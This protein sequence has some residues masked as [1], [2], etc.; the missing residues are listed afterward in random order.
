MPPLFGDPLVPIQASPPDTTGD[1]NVDD[2][3]AAAQRT[4]LV[5]RIKRPSSCASTDHTVGAPRSRLTPFRVPSRPNIGQSSAP[6][7]PTPQSPPHTTAAT[8]IIREMSFNIRCDLSF[9]MRDKN[10]PAFS[11]RVIL[12]RV[13]I[14]RVWHPTRCGLNS[15]DAIDRA[16][17]STGDQEFD[18]S[19]LSGK[20]S[21]VAR[22]S[23]VRATE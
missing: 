15:Q 10:A 16:A 13:D 9:V 20:S 19:K 11:F 3:S 22:G 23:N 14:F 12:F 7:E 6:V 17:E 8:T 21:R 1:E 2:P 18:K 4:P 5:S